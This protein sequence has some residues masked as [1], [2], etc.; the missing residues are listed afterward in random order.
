MRKNVILTS[1]F[2]FW[3]FNHFEV[4]VL[5][6]VLEYIILVPALFAAG[7][8]IY[9]RTLENW[10]IAIVLIVESCVVRKHMGVT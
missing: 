4:T 10:E 2:V 8:G 7:R 5:A 3:M 1:L 9:C 6:P